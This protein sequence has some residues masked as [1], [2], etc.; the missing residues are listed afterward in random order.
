MKNYLQ[1]GRSY[2]VENV[3]LRRINFNREDLAF[4]NSGE[5]KFYNAEH[6]VCFEIKVPRSGRRLHPRSLRAFARRQRFRQA[7]RPP[8]Q[9]LSRA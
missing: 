9:N 8:R 1:G 6:E 4:R 2:G 7:R 3:S 5:I